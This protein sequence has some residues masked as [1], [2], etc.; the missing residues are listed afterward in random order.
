VRGKEMGD[1]GARCFLKLAQQRELWGPVWGRR[2]EEGKGEPGTVWCGGG[3]GSERPVEARQR[4][5][6]VVGGT[7]EGWGA[8]RQ[9][10]GCNAQFDLIRTWSNP[11][12]RFKQ[13]LI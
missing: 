11:F 10:R 3:R 12:E 1:G 13:I 9:A 8:D 4:R 5:R 7:G 6:Q 2:V